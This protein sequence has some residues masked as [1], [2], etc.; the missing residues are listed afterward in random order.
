MNLY[1]RHATGNHRRHE[2]HTIFIIIAVKYIISFG[3][4]RGL[5][6]QLTIHKVT[7]IGDT[8]DLVHRTMVGGQCGIRFIRS[9]AVIE[10]IIRLVT[11]NLVSVILHFTNMKSDHARCPGTIGPKRQFV[12]RE[13]PPRIGFS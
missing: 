2:D 8:I 11:L 10:I 3:M 1:P 5:T 9:V 13:T 12:L 4:W 7:Q 6:I